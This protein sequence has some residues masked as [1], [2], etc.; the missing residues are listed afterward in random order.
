MRPSIFSSPQCLPKKLVGRASL[1]PQPILLHP[2]PCSMP[3]ALQLQ[4]ITSFSSNDAKQITTNYCISSMLSNYHKLLTNPEC[5]IRNPKQ[6]SPYAPPHITTSK[7]HHI[8]TSENPHITTSENQHTSLPYN[9]FLFRIPFPV[10][11]QYHHIHPRRQILGRYGHFFVSIALV[12][13]CR[14]AVNVDDV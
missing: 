6:A 13:G 2:A 7:N 11:F 10:Y 1:H 9:K 14:L 12:G 4:Q 5:G 8:L 3:H